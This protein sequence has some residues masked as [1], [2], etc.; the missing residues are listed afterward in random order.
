MNEPQS[1]PYIYG[2]M[3]DVAQIE[4]ECDNAAVSDGNLRE[5]EARS[6]HHSEV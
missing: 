5:C 3:Y 6:P 1:N 4:W 2:F